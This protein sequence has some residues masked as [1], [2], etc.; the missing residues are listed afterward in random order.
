MTPLSARDPFRVGVVAL[1][2]GGLVCA[3][4]VVLSLSTFG[5][6]DYTAVLAQTAG[7]RVGEDVSVH[8]VPAGTVKAVELAGDKVEVTFAL[9][10]DIR[11]GDAT[12]A[13]VKVATLLGTHYLEVD[14]GGDGELPG[15]RIPLS[16]TSVPFN[17]QDVLE[18][19]AEAVQE[20]NPQ[21]IARALTEAS[22]SMSASG[23]ALGPA[24]TGIARLSDAVSTRQGQTT[25]LLRAARRVTD[26]LSASTGD[27]LEM[28]RQADL[29]LDEVTRRRDAIDTLLTETTTLARN[30]RAITRDTEADLAPA[31]R[32]LNGVLGV[33]RSE[34]KQ[35]VK[36]LDTAAPA[37]RYV[38]NASGDGPWVQLWMYKSGLPADDTCTRLG[39]CPH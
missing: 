11:L 4:V 15:D 29:V 26:Q 23:E 9:E 14:P 2:V 22:E 17:L 34:K 24:L 5:K 19:G 3:G 28:M 20:L 32:K 13:E 8:G 7:L 10:R 21:V 12:T 38:A 6:K 33:L 16:R 18:R 35:L 27:L 37:V 30:L 31:F 25:Q 39:V 1:V 36:L